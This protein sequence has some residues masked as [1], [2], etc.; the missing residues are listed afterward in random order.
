MSHT[1]HSAKDIGSHRNKWWN[2]DFI[3]LLVNRSVSGKSHRLLDAGCGAGH[4]TISLLSSLQNV[5]SVTCLD[6]E[7][8]WICSAKENVQRAFSGIEVHT[9]ETD[10]HSIPIESKQFDITTC[11]TL[12]MHCEDPKAAL[13]E[14]LRVTKDDGML[15]L[16]E[17][18]NILNR[19]RFSQAIT[20][21]SPEQA[22][23]LLKSWM[24]YH[25]G[26]Q[27]SK[28]GNHDLAI[29][30]PSLLNSIG[31]NQFQVYQ[32]DCVLLSS[33]GADTSSIRSEIDQCNYHEIATIGGADQDEIE[34]FL[35]VTS[36][37]DEI[38]AKSNIQF[39]EAL[40]MYI[41]VVSKF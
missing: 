9:C 18:V 26:L 7:K 3:D 6:M 39:P 34:G 27:V 40:S 32:N 1:P 8:E 22:A 17:P 19:M 5:E 14:L 36:L 4:W 15:I 33:G 35:K 25:R 13:C 38:L 11:Q 10:V 21:L 12:L 16:V 23:T 37:F 28:M 31:H 29:T 24:Y 2:Q 41:Y 20:L 30:L